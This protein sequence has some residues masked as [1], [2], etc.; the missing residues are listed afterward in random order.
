MDDIL[1]TF[2]DVLDIIDELNDEVK[3]VASLQDL[4]LLSLSVK[5]ENVIV[6][7]YFGQYPIIVRKILHKRYYLLFEVI[8]HL[9]YEIQYLGEE[10]IKPSEIKRCQKHRSYTMVVPPDADSEVTLVLWNVLI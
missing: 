6:G 10:I 3:K 1:R 4:A 7:R 8:K 9:G 5:Q 2:D